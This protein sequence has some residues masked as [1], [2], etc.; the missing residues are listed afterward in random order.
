[1]SK[2]AHHDKKPTNALIARAVEICEA[3]RI[4]FLQ[5]SK[6]TFGNKVQSQLAEFKR[7]NGFEQLTFPRYYV[8]LT[9]TGRVAVKLKLYRSVIQIIP[10]P[11]VAILL[12]VRE[13]MLR[14]KKGAMGMDAAR[15]S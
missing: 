12:G 10:P 3:K 2:Q 14:L 8:P 13:A 11:L 5:Y 15:P 9:L 4:K 7:R 6:F 1:L